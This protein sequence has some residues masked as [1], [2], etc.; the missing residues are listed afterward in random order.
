[1]LQINESNSAKRHSRLGIAST[2]IGGGL[3]VLVTI[4]F[5]LVAVF[6]KISGETKSEFFSSLAG[7]SYIVFIFVGLSAPLLHLTGLI[8]GLIGVFSRK[9]KKLFP[10][11]GIILNLFF[12]LIGVGIIYFLLKHPPLYLN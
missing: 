8:F 12:G 11:A 2:I 10:I 1:M 7:I 4:L 9:T 6:S 5:I 3:P